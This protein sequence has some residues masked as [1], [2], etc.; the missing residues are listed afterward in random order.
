MGSI[1]YPEVYIGIVPG[2]CSVPGKERENMK[3]DG[4]FDLKERNTAAKKLRKDGFKVRCWTLP[5]QET[6]D[7]GMGSFGL[8][9]TDRPGYR[10]GSVYM[11]DVM[12]A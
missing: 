6:W 4:Y 11:I 2:A 12:E 1:I 3:Q 8:S 10:C 5:N 9:R 7:T